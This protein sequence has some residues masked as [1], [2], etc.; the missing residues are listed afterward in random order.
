LAALGLEPMAMPAALVASHGPF[1][2][3]ASATDA[4]ANA[5]ALEAVAT[6]AYRTLALAPTAADIAADLRDRHFRR[7]HGPSAYYGQPGSGRAD[8]D[9]PD[10]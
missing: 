10:R 3:G 2:W 4:V 1:T 9:Q 7:K 6:I 5:V 8:I